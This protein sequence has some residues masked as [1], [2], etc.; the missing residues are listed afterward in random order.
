MVMNASAA[1]DVETQDGFNQGMAQPPI[2]VQ[3]IVDAHDVHF[4]T[5]RRLA[6]SD[7]FKALPDIIQKVMFDHMMQHQMDFGQSQIKI[8]VGP[9]AG[10]QPTPVRQGGSV[11]VTAGG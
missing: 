10:Q 5:H 4:L 11:P 9:G 7:E 3:P 1:P 6:L 2:M 8:P